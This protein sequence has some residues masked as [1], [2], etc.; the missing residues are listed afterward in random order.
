ME[1]ETR[2][3]GD[4]WILMSQPEL[5]KLVATS[6]PTLQRVMRRL[7]NAGF[8]RSSYARVQILDRDALTRLCKS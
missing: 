7:V 1:V 6:V 5:A 3:D 2:G 8:V 4:D